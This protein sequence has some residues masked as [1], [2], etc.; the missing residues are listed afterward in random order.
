M[1]RERSNETEALF[2]KLCAVSPA[3]PIKGTRDAY[4]ELCPVDDKFRDEFS[5]TSFTSNVIDRA[6][7]CLEQIEMSK[8]GDYD[9]LQ[10]LGAEDVHVEHI[11]PQKIKTKKAKDE[12][13]DWVTYLG[14]KA[15]TQHQKYVSRIGNLTIF[16]GTLNIGASNNPFQKKKQAYKESGIKLTQELLKMTQF[17]FKNVEQRSRDLAEIAVGL[18][19]M[20]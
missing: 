7:Y 6:R 1:C 20:P 10:V 17:K 5:T 15:E 4:R 2:A 13:G 11:I 9:E 12:F 18:W 8:H 19:P 14:E 3:N 16:S